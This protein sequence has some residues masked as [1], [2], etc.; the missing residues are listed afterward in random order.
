MSVKHDLMRLGSVARSRRAFA[1]ADSWRRGQWMQTATGRAF[2]PLDP[3]PED[4]CIQDIAA[5][6]S[7][8]CRYAGQLRDDVGHYSI[9][10]HSVCLARHFYARGETA[11]ARWA[12][13][14]DAAEFC[15]ELI[16]P[17]KGAVPQYREIEAR[18]MGV[19]CARFGLPR[20]EPREVKYADLRILLDERE[21]VMSR[22]PAA[23]DVD[24]LDPLGAVI[25][26]YPA[27]MARFA[28]LYWFGRL[29]PEEPLSFAS[30]ETGS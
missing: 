14:H 13:M 15:G 18:I 28:F 30:R 2:Y 19:I 3:R 23:W 11:L 1:N 29:F 16:R 27:R 8:Q 9:A 22:P 20:D 26:C 21:A 6:L 5:G 7:R 25:V 4:I 17:I 24:E 12:L 10:E